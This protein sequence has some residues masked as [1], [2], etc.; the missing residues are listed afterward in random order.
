MFICKSPIEELNQQ[1][2]SE[3]QQTRALVAELETRLEL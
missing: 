1:L 2:R 3:L